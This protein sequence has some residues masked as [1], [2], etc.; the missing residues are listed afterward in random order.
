MFDMNAKVVCIDDRFPIGINDIFNALPRK[1]GI[2]TVRDIVPAQDWR[3][4]PTCAVLL[5]EL[6]NRPNKHGIEPGFAPTRF[7]EPTADE[8]R[9]IEAIEA[10]LAN[11]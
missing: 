9:M 7:R 4:Q 3:L 2:Y 5:W 10:E 1:G 11:H 6:E 8:Q